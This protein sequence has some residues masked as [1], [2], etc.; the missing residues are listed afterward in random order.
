MSLFHE[1]EFAKTFEKSDLAYCVIKIILNENNEPLDWEFVYLNDALAR[2]EGVKKECLLHRRFFEVFP[3]ADRKWFKYYYPAAFED[4]SFVFEEVSE[5][6]GS[7]LRIRCFPVEYGYCACMLEDISQEFQ[8]LSAEGR[9]LLEVCDLMKAARWTVAFDEEEEIRSTWFSDE[10]RNVL[11]FQSEQ[12][13]PNDMEGCL[14]RVHPED[15]GDVRLAFRRAV[16]DKSN[17]TPFNYQI[18]VRTKK[19][20]YIWVRVGMKIHRD[21]KG[22]AKELIGVFVDVN[23]THIR[24]QQQQELEQ[25]K[26]ALQQALLEMKQANQAKTR[27]LN[28]MAHDIRTPMNAVIGFTELAQQNL[29]NREKLEEYLLKIQS[30]SNH[31][32]D[33]INDVLEMSRIE[34]GVVD[35]QEKTENLLE[36]IED[37][38][39][40]I[41]ADIDAKQLHFEVDV[42]RIEHPVIICDRLRTHQIFLNIY[43]NA[44]KYTPKG[45]TI[46]LCVVEKE[47][48]KKGFGTYIFSVK[49]T[50]IGMSEAFQ[51]RLFE[52]FTREHTVTQDGIEGTGLGMSIAKNFVDLMGGTII[53]N[54]KIN[55]GT[56]FVVTFDFQQVEELSEDSFDGSLIEDKE[57]VSIRNCKKPNQMS[58]SFQGK[59]ILLAEDNELNLELAE[60]ILRYVDLQVDSAIN[61]EEACR[62]IAQAK[63][64]YYDMVL[65]DI[66]M[67]IL[68]GYEAAKRIREHE[69]ETIA[70][71]PI[72]AMTADAFVEDQ[73]AALLAGMNGHIAKPIN[74]QQL[75]EKIQDLIG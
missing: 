19:E 33:L 20:E 41:R 59:R 53:C 52:P 62:L 55:E 3:N 32:L 66:Q 25:T 21:E 16:A 36:L 45:G 72:V 22:K 31:L 4:K 75:Y 10:F 57:N 2:I 71:I 14:L 44:I 9:E 51:Q 63:P 40:M 58:Y 42:E 65:M 47:S 39:D 69:N 1:L 18:R 37:S 54:S 67:P 49:D 68:N 48:V 60:N 64:G 23:D 30:S 43:T 12:E 56:E 15:V 35:I 27:F 73:E 38:S 13:F 5:E 26:E 70:N 29:D 46:S 34:S 61:G 28:S 7:V 6:I 17:Q 11:G 24:E 8:T 74:R 50:G